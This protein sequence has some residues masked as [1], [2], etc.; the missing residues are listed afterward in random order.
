M[1]W[2]SRLGKLTS[3]LLVSIGLYQIIY[4]AA[5][6]ILVYPKFKFG[7]G[8][9]SLLIY[10][11]LIEKA[12]VYYVTMVINGIYGLTLMFKSKEEISYLQIIVGLLVFGFSVF[13]VTETPFTTDPISNLFIEFLRK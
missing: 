1:S 9:S 4:S 8:Q 6:L 10:E 11:S 12:I 7:S 3:I 2:K 5:L 13:F